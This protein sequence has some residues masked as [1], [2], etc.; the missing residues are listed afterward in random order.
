MFMEIMDILLHMIKCDKIKKC[1][2]NTGNVM[3]YGCAYK[4]YNTVL[5]YNKYLNVYLCIKNKKN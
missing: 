4:I 3:L 1:V 2:M 5:I